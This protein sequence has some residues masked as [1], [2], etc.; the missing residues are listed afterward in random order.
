V[1][2]PDFSP[3][4]DSVTAIK[5]AILQTARLCGYNVSFIDEDKRVPQ[6]ERILLNREDSPRILVTHWLE[7]QSSR[8]RMR[9]KL[10]NDDR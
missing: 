7:T 9:F 5:E 8:I 10:E 2:N 4:L 3:F 6:E 1:T